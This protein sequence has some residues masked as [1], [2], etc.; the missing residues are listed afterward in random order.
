MLCEI[1]GLYFYILYLSTCVDN[2]I[3][4][5]PCSTQLLQQKYFTITTKRGYNPVGN[6]GSTVGNLRSVMVIEP[7]VVLESGIL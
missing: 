2:S 6:L 5:I 4:P 3:T 7:M 1:L